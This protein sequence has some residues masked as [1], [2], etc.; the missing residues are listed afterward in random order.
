MPP[1]AT[2]FT[3]YGVYYTATGSA[4]AAFGA[5]WLGWD[6]HRACAA[7]HPE[8]QGL[9]LPVSEITQTPRRYGFHATIVPPFQLA[10][11][12]LPLRQAL[13]DYCARTPA[14]DLQGLEMAQLGRFLALVPEQSSDALQM[15]AAGAVEACDAFRVPLAPSDLERHR[16]RGLSEAQDRLLIRWGYPYVKQEFRFHMTLTGKLPKAQTRR[17]RDVLAPRLAPLL[18]RP[19]TI[20]ALSLVGENEAGFFQVIEDIALS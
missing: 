11:D 4:L 12:L 9:P 2:T 6:M 16:K 14:V 13:R 17:V 1:E 20:D 3:R 5:A 19:V 10:G 7:P 15:L 18:P 8:L